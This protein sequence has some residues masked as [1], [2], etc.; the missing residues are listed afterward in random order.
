M[1]RGKTLGQSLF[2]DDSSRV[3]VEFCGE[4]A[5]MPVL[6]LLAPFLMRIT[7]RCLIPTLTAVLLTA[8]PAFAA[9]SVRIVTGPD[10]PK[11]ERFAAEELGTQ[12]GRLFQATTTVTD[13]VP[14]GSDP[15]ILLGSPKTNPAIAQTIGTNWPKLSEQGH[16]LKSVKL[17][18]RPALLV[19]GGSPVATLW[20]V[21]ELDHQFG[22]R[23]LLHGDVL[24]EKPPAFTLDGFSVT[25]EPRIPLRGFQLLDDSPIGFGGWGLDDQKQFLRQLAKLKFNRIIFGLNPEQPRLAFDA[26]SFPVVGDTPGRKVFKG[27]KVFDN[28]DLAGK[29]GDARTQALRELRNAIRT[30]GHDL[31]LEVRPLSPD[32]KPIELRGFL[33][34]IPAGTVPESGFF[35][36]ADV[37]GDLSPT[38]YLYSRSAFDK[39]LTVAAAWE[40]LLTPIIGTAS[41][42]RVVLGFRKIDEAAALI[43]ANDPDF[44]KLTAAFVPE[45]LQSDAVPPAWWKQAKTLYGEG[46]NEMYR[47]IRGTFHNPARP[48]LL[49]YAKRCECAVHYFTALEAI[50][51]AG[52]A[53][54]QGHTDEALT[55][56]GKA[57]ESVYN[58]LNAYADVARDP[59]DRGA[60]AVLAATVYRPLKA[61]SKALRKAG[62]PE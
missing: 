60:I 17:G 29:T 52:V 53:R 32:M 3:P 57:T 46:M 35:L 7:M 13:T 2:V 11:L 48:T 19:G 24:P 9:P 15:V 59:S 5:P 4:L 45:R 50:R 21:Y 56:L 27:A 62:R 30:A 26:K 38:A 51:L 44:F 47:G 22:V 14:P 23:A 16:L 40:Q 18:D 41:A 6:W 34:R 61:E 28:P 54:S 49:Y 37:P 33:P 1:P 20:A 12:L 10:A 39:N 43:A 55:Q 31:G 8:L 25:L 42:E 58:A 36:V